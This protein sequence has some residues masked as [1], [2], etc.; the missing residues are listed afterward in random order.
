[1]VRRHEFNSDWWGENAGI[2][3]DPAFFELPLKEQDTMLSPYAW[4]EFRALAGLSP[5]LERI[6]QAGFSQTDV[7]IRYRL[8]FSR[9]KTSESIENLTIRFADEQH[10]TIDVG[11]TKSFIHERFMA[12]PGITAQKLNERYAL[13]GNR[14]ISECPE[15]CV[16]VFSDSRLQ[17]WFLSQSTSER[18]NLTLAMLHKDASIPGSLLYQ[19]ALLAYRERGEHA[20][21]SS[22]SATNPAV[23][24]IFS[25]LGARFIKPELFWIWIMKP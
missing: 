2:V 25:S 17:G 18:L 4:V 7:Q 12:L 15:R 24:N 21:G 1:M 13:W 9:I 8:T 16:Q 23:L 19:K 14:I 10:F 6:Q 3:T 20:G 22:F 11:D 5:P